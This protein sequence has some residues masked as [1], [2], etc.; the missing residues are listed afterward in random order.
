MYGTAVTGLTRYMNRPPRATGMAMAVRL[1]RDATPPRVDTGLPQQEAG[2]E[3]YCLM[4]PR[5][6]RARRAADKAR[7]LRDAQR[8]SQNL[9]RAR[10]PPRLGRESFELRHIIRTGGIPGYPGHPDTKTQMDPRQEARMHKIIGTRAKF[11]HLA[12]EE[13]EAVLAEAAAK[14]E[15]ADVTE[16]E[17]EVRRA[18]EAG[19]QCVIDAAEVR[20]AA[21]KEE[22]EIA[23]REAAVE[24]Q[25]ANAAAAAA[26]AEA[27]RAQ[28]VERRAKARPPG[29]PIAGRPDKPARWM[30]GGDLPTFRADE[31]SATQRW[32]L[33]RLANNDPSLTSLDWSKMDLHDGIAQQL[34]NALR[35][36]TYLRWLD[37][38]F[39]QGLSDLACGCG[40]RDSPAASSLQRA[41]AHS[42]VRSKA[43]TLWLDFLGNRGAR[44][45]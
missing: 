9:L 22:A 11:S 38:R 21:E 6:E 24:R 4:S 33:V 35:G 10:P 37:L 25:Q 45:S 39:N 34:G 32:Y 16:A 15:L 7:R 28:A 23:Q 1:P 18:K 40:K 17:D 12:T 44:H 43:N 2:D 36:N 19:D 26:I 31:Q 3:D 27:E 42:S 20:L 41:L 8:P 30:N 14:R 5:R 13:A 29:A